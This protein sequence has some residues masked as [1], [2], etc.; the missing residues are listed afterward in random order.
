MILT[1]A[2]Y[3]TI[4]GNNTWTYNES[5]DPGPYDITII[6]AMGTVT[7]IERSQM[8]QE[9][10]RTMGNHKESLGVGQAGR[11]LIARAVDKEVLAPLWKKYIGYAEHDPQQMIAFL[12]EKACVPL[13]TIEQNAMKQEGLDRPW[14]TAENLTTYWTY[15][16]ELLIKLR[17]KNINISDDERIMSA[18]TRMWE[19]D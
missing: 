2:K 9:H 4:I 8:K 6:N 7:Q 3:R 14:N 13:T 18:V 10:K 12:R 11:E 16:D 19:S 15:L 1:E 5:V 17:D